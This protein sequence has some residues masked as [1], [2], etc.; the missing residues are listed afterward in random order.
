MKEIKLRN[1]TITKVDDDD[2]DKLSQS[3]WCQDA[4]GYI[5][6]KEAMSRLIMNAKIGEIV[7]HINGD[8]LDNRK[9]NLRIVTMSQNQ[10]NRKKKSDKFSSNFKG[11]Y[12]VKRDNVWRVRISFNKTRYYLGEF[13]NEIEAAKR[14]NEEAKKLFKE[15]AKLNIIPG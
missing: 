8:I 12:W 2:F 6:K 11:V 7:D 13:T 1:G 3:N 5:V 15:Y 4:Y 9:C 14:Y 10:M